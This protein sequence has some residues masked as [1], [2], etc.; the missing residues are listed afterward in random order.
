MIA[1]DALRSF[2]SRIERVDEDIKALNADKKAIYEDMRGQGFDVK[3]FK[4]AHRRHMAHA[5]NPATA[6]E[7]EALTDLYFVALH[8]AEG[9]ESPPAAKSGAANSLPEKPSRA[10]ARSGHSDPRPP[11]PGAPGGETA[12]GEGA[13]DTTAAPAAPLPEPLPTAVPPDPAAGQV[14]ETLPPVVVSATAYSDQDTDIPAFLRRVKP[15]G[16][17][18]DHILENVDL[19]P[20]GASPEPR[21]VAA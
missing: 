20:M 12:A 15:G 9:A 5:D 16:A 18:E 19:G 14:A 13:S 8:G 3:A 6:Q 17:P 11:S 4:S 2:A 1:R 7:D 21:G 10:R